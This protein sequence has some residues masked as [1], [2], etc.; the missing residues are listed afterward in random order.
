MRFPQG[1]Q[2]STFSEEWASKNDFA[3]LSKKDLKQYF[4][5][6]LSLGILQW[7][8]L[9]YPG[10]HPSIAGWLGCLWRC[11]FCRCQNMLSTEVAKQT[12]SDLRV[13][14]Y[15]HEEKLDPQPLKYGFLGGNFQTV[16]DFC[17]GKKSMYKTQYNICCGCT[18]MMGCSMLF[19]YSICVLDVLTSS[20][21]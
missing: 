21:W 5:N 10:H 19:F 18:I 9:S 6:G 11:G 15:W 20:N 1:L 13:L 16:A 17:L 8:G 4:R 2:R 3:T 7:F 12:F 14:S